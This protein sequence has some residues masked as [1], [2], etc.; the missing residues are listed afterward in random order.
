M[1]YFKKQFQN[2]V[3]RLPFS[4]AFLSFKTL[5]FFSINDEVLDIPK[6][7]L[8]ITQKYNSKNINFTQL[9]KQS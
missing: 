2:N 1:I 9:K 8:G 4:Y 5:F 3:K 6:L 7:D